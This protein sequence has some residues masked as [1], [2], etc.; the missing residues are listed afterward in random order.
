MVNHIIDAFLQSMVGGERLCLLIEC[1]IFIVKKASLG[2]VP[3]VALVPIP[4]P[5][6]CAQS[7]INCPAFFHSKDGGTGIIAFGGDAFLP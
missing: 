5:L 7:S 6:I 1:Q 3:L 2:F 4:L